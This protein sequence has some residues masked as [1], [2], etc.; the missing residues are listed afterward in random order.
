MQGTGIDSCSHDLP[1]DPQGKEYLHPQKDCHL[2]QQLTS[3][4]LDQTLLKRAEKLIP[5]RYLVFL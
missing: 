1:T 4:V 3:V 2:L 5:Y